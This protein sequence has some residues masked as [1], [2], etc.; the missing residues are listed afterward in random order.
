[1][2]AMGPVAGQGVPGGRNHRSCAGFDNG[3][4]WTVSEAWCGFAPWF[5]L[6]LRHMPWWNGR[7]V[8]CGAG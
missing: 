8:V 3:G 5:R 1:M 2:S 7:S 6:Y 4:V